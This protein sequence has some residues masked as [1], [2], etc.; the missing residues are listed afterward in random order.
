MN[1]LDPT[2]AIDL[3]YLGVRLP[4]PPPGVSVEPLTQELPAP[5]GVCSAFVSRTG[6]TTDVTQI[7]GWR[8]KFSPSETLVA[9]PPPRPEAGPGPD[10]PKK[11]LSAFCSDM[12]DQYLE[13]EGKLIDQRAA[14]FSPPPVEPPVYE[15]PTRSTSYV[16]TLDSILKKQTGTSDLISGFVPPSKRP[17]PTL[18]ET[19]TSRRE[20]SKQRGPKHYKPEPAAVPSQADSNLVPKQPAVQIPDSPQPPTFKRRKKLKP[21][22][23][24]Q[25]LSPHRS[26]SPPPGLSEDLAPLESDSELGTAL[27]QNYETS[28][29]DGGPVMTR[30]LL[31]QKDLEDGVVWEGQPRTSIT[32][33]RAAIALTS[34]FT[35]QVQ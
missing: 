7:K 2:L 30:T 19:R 20:S 4:I 15:L 23:L 13:N 34:L 31:K 24:S 26:T 9:P 6:K 12:L 14:S 5:Q 3:Q 27:D 16:R 1:L 8:E 21:R 11:N 18:K 35:L 28:R 22:S 29:K 32:E 10:V 17:K 33:E 25:T